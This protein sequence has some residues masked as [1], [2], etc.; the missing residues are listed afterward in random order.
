MLLVCPES[1]L[2]LS[3]SSCTSSNIEAFSADDGATCGAAAFAG[4]GAVGL[5]CQLKLVE[6]SRAGEL[7]W[8]GKSAGF[9]FPMAYWLRWLGDECRCWL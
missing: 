9:P 5:L 1:K 6:Q 3:S 2:M 4:E 7:L 8:Q